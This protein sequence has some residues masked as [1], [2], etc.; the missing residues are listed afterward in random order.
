MELNLPLVVEPKKVTTLMV[1][2]EGGGKGW[3][4]L[5]RGL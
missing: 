2:V 4:M 3:R 1:S 5:V